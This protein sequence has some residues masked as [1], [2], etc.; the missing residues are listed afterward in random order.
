MRNWVA[1]RVKDGLEQE[2]SKS[3]VAEM[4]VD[5]Y[6]PMMRRWVK[7]P[8]HLRV[9]EGRVR[10][11]VET[12][13]L[14]GYIFAK[15]RPEAGFNECLSNIKSVKGVYGFVS[16]QR[17]V[18]LARDSD[19]EGVRDHERELRSGKRPVALASK[20][21]SEKL[22]EVSFADAV[23][24]SFK[25]SDGPFQGIVGKVT[26]QRNGSLLFEVG[27]ASLAVDQNLLIA[28]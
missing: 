16:T 7:L 24:K 23:G 27:T 9:K 8:R 19:I 14:E 17:G 10:K 26:G 13:L 15:I 2:I 11:L 25:I 20:E 12:A 4:S 21:V 1:V 28:V 6:C 22:A 3:L 18:C 5:C